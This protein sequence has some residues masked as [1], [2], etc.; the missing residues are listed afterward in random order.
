M[1]YFKNLFNLSEEKS[2]QDE[3]L[4]SRLRKRRQRDRENVIRQTNPFDMILVVKNKSNGEL[5]IIDKESYDP[6]YHEILIS[7]EQ[8]NQSV[9]SGILKDPKFVQ[10]ETSKRLFG[11]VKQNQPKEEKTEEKSVEAKQSGAE[12]GPVVQTITTPA[13]KREI[14]FTKS[15]QSS[16]PII[17]LGMMSG[18]QGKELQKLGITPQQLEE[19]NSSTEI[20]D[21]SNKIAGEI[22][23]YFKNVIGREI[24]EYIPTI[25]DEQQFETTDMWKLMGGYDSTPKSNIVFTHICVEA[26]G[27]NEKCKQNNC[28]CIKAGV[29]S[30]EI[31]LSFNMKY[32]PSSLIN[33]KLNND[34]ETT[35]FST[36]NII[37]QLIL[38]KQTGLNDDLDEKETKAIGKIQSDIEFIKNISLQKIEDKIIRPSNFNVDKTQTIEDIKK[39]A[40]DVK[41]QIERVINSNILYKEMYVYE[42]LTGY[43]KFG[44][45]SPAFSGGVIAVEPESYNVAMRMVD[46]DFV[47][48][49]VDGQNKIAFNLKTN[50]LESRDEK[51]NLEI[52][53]ARFGG[54]C[55]K[56]STPQRFAIRSILLSYMTESKFNHSNLR[57]LL[58]QK[59]SSILIE[60]F[61]T[62]LKNTQTMQE[63]MNI[64]SVTP[65]QITITPID[66]FLATKTEYSSERNMIKVNGKLFQIPVQ[67]DQ[68]TPNDL[69]DMTE[70]FSML[71]KL[72]ERNYRKEYDNYHGTPEQRSNRSKRVLARRKKEKQVG[73]NALN[74]KDVDHKD[75]DPQNNNMSNLRVRDRSENRAD[76]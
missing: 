42:A 26:S 64:F 23:F 11:D 66:L 51:T 6:R 32:G 22:K 28:E 48:K 70:S 63:L 19:Y 56:A 15:N 53:K 25:V 65:A 43:V 44:S 10:T 46:F 31:M 7:P 36:V 34:T 20:Q 3:R 67:I 17:S 39:I 38:N 1:K 52:C 16:G 54:K 33:G 75:G 14:P 30:T 13:P 49:I 35:F 71:S 74:G 58:E 37:D 68:S 12:T 45:Q 2:A 69:E 72:M 57:Y 59:D 50:L 61:I 73:K 62:L 5:L 41:I 4:G 18:M 21:I 60:E 27:K 47:R 9:I 76:H 24:T 29:S 55:P 40:E 8:I